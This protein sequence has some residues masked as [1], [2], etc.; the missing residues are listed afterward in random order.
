MRASRSERSSRGRIAATDYDFETP[1]TSLL[2]QASRRRGREARA[3]RLSRA[4]TRQGAGDAI[5]TVRIERRRTWPERLVGELVLPRRS[6]P[7][8]AFAARRARARRRER[9]VPAPDARHAP[10]RHTTTYQNSFEAM[11]AEP[12]P[13]A[14][15]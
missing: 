10:G 3:L 14:R 1:S 11:P 15:A 13:P 5:A 4:T 9:R 2:S 8:T 12:L 7:G 6:R